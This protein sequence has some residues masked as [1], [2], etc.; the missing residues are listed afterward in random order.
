MEIARLFWTQCLTFEVPFE[1]L[2]IFGMKTVDRHKKMGEI[3]QLVSTPNHECKG[4][5]L[6]K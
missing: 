1:K 5:T 2:L 4:P 6:K 3:S